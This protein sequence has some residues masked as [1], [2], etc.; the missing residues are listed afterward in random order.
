MAR[1]SFRIVRYHRNP[2]FLRGC[3]LN[4]ASMSAQMIGLRPSHVHLCCRQTDG[5]DEATITAAEA[6][7]SADER[8]RRDRF[9]FECDKR[10][11]TI[12][13]GLLRRSLSKFNV[14]PPAQWVFEP[15]NRGKPQVSQASWQTSEHRDGRLLSFSLSHT[16][17]VVAF[18]IASGVS[19]GVDVERINPNI[20]VTEL[21]DWCLSRSETL[22][23]GRLRGRARMVR[24]FEIW[25]LKEAFVKAT[26]LG[27]SEAL[28]DISFNLDDTAAPSLFRS[29]AGIDPAAGGLPFMRRLQMSDWPRP[30]T[31][32]TTF[33][34]IRP[35]VSIEPLHIAPARIHIAPARKTSRTI[36]PH[37]AFAKPRMSIEERNPCP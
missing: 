6:A 34:A 28:Q 31:A 16:R 14:V 7:L 11:Y 24:F 18:A 37:S 29:P 15:D 5:L 4:T 26:G 30:R 13:H 35:F 33:P 12:A 1:P 36:Y 2:S 9:R 21:A 20:V 10:D 27:L 3:P 25:T 8:N 22:A 23:L 32:A 19:V 17:G